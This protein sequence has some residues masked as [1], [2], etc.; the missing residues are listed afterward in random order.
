MGTQVEQG[1]RPAM[2]NPGTRAAM[3]DQGTPWAMT[4]SPPP[5]KKI[6]WEIRSADAW[7]ALWKRGRL[8]SALEARTLGGALWK[9]GRLGWNG[10][11]ELLDR[12]G[13][14]RALSR[15]RNGWALSR[16]RHGRA[17]WAGV[18]GGRRDPGSGL[19]TLQTSDDRL[20]PMEVAGVEEFWCWRHWF[21]RA[22]CVRMRVQTA[23]K[24]ITI[25]HK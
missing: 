13:L 11:C 8:G 20:L 16:S 25:I 1:A 14:C 17:L 23:D 10:L 6:Y 21:M 2:A 18:S 15:S 5:P 7:G 24:N 4:G 3:A 12:S 9:R 19:E 22:V